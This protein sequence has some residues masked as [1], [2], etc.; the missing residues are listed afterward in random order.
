MNEAGPLYI[1]AI[2][3][4]PAGVRDVEFFRVG[5]A[6]VAFERR[7]A[8]PISIEAAVAHDKVVQRIAKACDAVLPLRFGTT[9][10]DEKTLAKQ[11]S[12]L[13]KAIAD[14]LRRVHD[15]VQLT[16]RVSGTPQPVESAGGPGAKY[17]AARAQRVPE[18]APLTLATRAFVRAAR[19][20]RRA[21]GASFA[22]VYHLVDRASLAEWRRAVKKTK[23]EGVT[24][25][26]SGPWPPYAFADLL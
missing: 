26:V 19:A 6:W 23:L 24:I 10:S 14:A 18:I 3:D 17:L 4:A 8:E 21:V 12:P 16:I 9:A 11:L 25:T 1:Y 20:E 13:R 15:A 7:P 2:V 5:Q 22:T